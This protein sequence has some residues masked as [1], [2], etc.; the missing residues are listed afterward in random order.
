[1]I[2]LVY[3]IFST[4]VSI[5]WIN[6]IAIVFGYIFAT[7]IVTFISLVPGFSF[8]FTF[9]SLLFNKS[10]KNKDCHVKCEEDVTILIPVYN[11]EDTIIETINTIKKQKYC[12]NIFTTIIDDGSTD[13]TLEILREED[14]G[15][16]FKVIPAKHVGKA[17]ALNIGLKN[18]NT[19]YVVTVDSDTL[20]HELAIKKMMDKIVNSSEKIVATAGKLFVKNAKKNFITKIQEWDYTLGI[21][22][23][24]LL[25]G[26]YNSTLV[27][28]GAF[29][30]YKTEKLKEIGGWKS[31]VGED[32]VLTWELL[33]KGYETNFAENAIGFTIVPESLS[34]LGNQRKRWA[35]G[36]IEVFKK[37][38]TLTST[39]ISIKAKTLMFFNTFFPFIDLALLIFVPLGLFLL[40]RGNRLLISWISL[41]VILLGLMLC[42]LIEIRRKEA[43][44]DICFELEKRSKLAFLFYILIYAFVLA[45]YCLIGYIS[46]IFNLKKTW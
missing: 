10:I 24:K 11:A 4:F 6:D 19:K 29:S 34:K 46:E 37:V 31:C 13:R 41:L 30:A 42:K 35:R 22:R 20:L 27:A 17:N 9:C 15:S 36:M 43:L 25:Q 7:Y 33:S 32:I 23:V 1:M 21:F 16:N 40:S 8:I 44:E 18:T 45:P 12:E 38:K 14:L 26:N 3:L 39:K 2:A 5:N 28:Q